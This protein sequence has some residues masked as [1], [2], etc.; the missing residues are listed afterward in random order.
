MV[1]NTHPKQCLKVVWIT[2]ASLATGLGFE[3]TAGIKFQGWLG[4]NGD[5]EWIRTTGPQIRNLVLYPTELRDH[6]VNTAS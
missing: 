4:N 5:P 1:M 6:S 2:T 3:R